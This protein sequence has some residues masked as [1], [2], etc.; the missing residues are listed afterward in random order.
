MQRF[1][2]E[3]GQYFTKIPQNYTSSSPVHRAHGVAARRLKIYSCDPQLGRRRKHRISIEAGLG[4]LVSPLAVTDVLYDQTIA[5]R[6]RWLNTRYRIAV[7]VADRLPDLAL[8]GAT[9]Q[10]DRSP[11]GP[12]GRYAQLSDEQG[13]A[14]AEVIA[15]LDASGGRAR[16]DAEAMAN[17]S[18]GTTLSK[19]P[20]DQAASPLRHAYVVTMANCHVL[21]DHP[22]LYVPSVER[23]RGW[24]S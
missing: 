17:R 14:A 24:V 7:R 13:K 22:M 16:W 21:L 9:I 15:R 18:V 11:Y 10:I 4:E 3:S 6:R 1:D 12:P 19:I 20:A 2:V 23:A 5:L 8:R